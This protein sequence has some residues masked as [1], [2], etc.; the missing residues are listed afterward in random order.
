ML[1]LKTMSCVNPIQ[2]TRV[3][4]LWLKVEAGLAWAPRA[5]RAPPE[6]H[7]SSRL[8]LTVS[9]TGGAMMLKALALGL[10]E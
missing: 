5:P 3:G 7:L 8:A 9:G 4:S 1:S 2:K 6:G 10:K